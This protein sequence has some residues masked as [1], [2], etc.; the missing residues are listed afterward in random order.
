MPCSIAHHPA[1]FQR[2]IDQIIVDIPHWTVF[3]D[4]R[5]LIGSNE[6]ENVCILETKSRELS[7]FGF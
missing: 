1:I 3:L 7:N 2:I 6:A 5:L 4:D